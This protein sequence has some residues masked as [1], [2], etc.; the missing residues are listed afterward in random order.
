MAFFL[1][2]DAVMLS[3]SADVPATMEGVASAMSTW[4]TAQPDLDLTQPLSTIPL[5]RQDEKWD[6]FAA[7]VRLS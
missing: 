4:R 6:E 2:R 3:Q 1:T 7:L 5:V